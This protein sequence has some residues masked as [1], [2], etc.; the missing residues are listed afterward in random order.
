VSLDIIN[1]LANV[2]EGLIEIGEKMGTPVE[3][4][5]SLTETYL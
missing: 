2:T 1:K 4:G 3:K 5:I